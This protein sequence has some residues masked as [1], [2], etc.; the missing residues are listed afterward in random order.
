MEYWPGG[1][2]QRI[3][4]NSKK[5]AIRIVANSK[6]ND[7]TEPLFKSLGILKLDD[8]FKQSVLKFYYS[9]CYVS[10]TLYF[11]S[12]DLNLRAE[13]HNYNIRSNKLFHTNKIRTK[14]AEN[15]LRNVLP[16]LLNENS[17]SILDKIAT[18]SFEGYIFF[19]KR[20]ILDQYNISCTIHN[21][22][23]CNG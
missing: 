2:I 10:L 6:Y 22:Y 4:L 12:F 7:H 15:S 1:E 20:T 21:C 5:K 9:Y 14:M 17:P 3:S 16:K 8:V 13:C 23:I 19:I 18:H 11:Q